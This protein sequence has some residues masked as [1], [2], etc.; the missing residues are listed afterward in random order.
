MKKH[1]WATRSLLDPIL[2]H[3]LLLARLSCEVVARGNNKR[4]SKMAHI[5]QILNSRPART[6]YDSLTNDQEASG[7][8]GL[9]IVTAET[10]PSPSPFFI[11]N[12]TGTRFD[13]SNA[14]AAQV[15]IERCNKDPSIE[16]I[17]GKVIGAVELI[18]CKGTS[19]TI[20]DESSSPA[21]GAQEG[22]SEPTNSYGTITVD[23]SEKVRIVLPVPVTSP[24]QP[25]TSGWTIY[26]SKC[27]DL[28]LECT[29]TEGRYKV[30]ADENY[31]PTAPTPSNPGGSGPIRLKTTYVDGKFVTKPCNLYGDVAEQTPAPGVGR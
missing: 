6:V 8:N 4:E 1:V 25:S 12:C 5:F 24:G 3:L 16:V 28:I 18:Q 30:P 19:V 15:T 21:A 13:L 9:R 2:G 10:R 7:N 27:A 17:I 20:I 26:T 23:S 11:T 29:G 22:N 14:K 31:V